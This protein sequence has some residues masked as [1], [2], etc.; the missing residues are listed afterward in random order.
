MND[1]LKTYSP[2]DNSLYVERAFANNHEIQGAL[3]KAVADKKTVG[4]DHYN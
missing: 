1:T 4:Y 3:D 2:I